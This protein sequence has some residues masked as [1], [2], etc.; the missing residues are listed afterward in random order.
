[1]EESRAAVAGLC[2]ELLGVA[3]ELC[4]LIGGLQRWTTA[5]NPTQQRLEGRPGLQVEEQAPMH[6]SVVSDVA[7]Q[8]THHIL[9]RQGTGQ[10]AGTVEPPGP[11]D[12]FAGWPVLQQ[13]LLK[14]S[15]QPQQQARVNTALDTNSAPPSF[16]L[17][18]AAVKDPATGL[19]LIDPVSGLPV[20]SIASLQVG[21]CP[22]A[23]RTH[24]CKE[25]QF[26]NDHRCMTC[27]G[28]GARGACTGAIK[29]TS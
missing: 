9:Q 28:S 2:E 10:P 19:A 14:T 26:P 17:E 25:L 24:A 20:V 15:P 8:G 18:A 27:S 5:Q 11:S 29:S 16:S 1:M 7:A 6:S 22:Q 13:E 4:S 21:S 12:Q 23:S 3:S